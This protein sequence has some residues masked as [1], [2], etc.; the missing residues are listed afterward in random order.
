MTSLVFYVRNYGG[1]ILEEQIYLILSL[2]SKKRNPPTADAIY[3]I[4]S[5]G[6][7]PASKPNKL[8]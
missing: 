1:Y 6:R 3:I 4:S 5:L 8:L 2:N 7:N